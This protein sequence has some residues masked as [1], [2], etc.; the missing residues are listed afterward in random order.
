MILNY[1]DYKNLNDIENML[2]TGENAERKI[3]DKLKSYRYKEIGKKLLNKIINHFLK[4]DK[5]T[6]P[7]KYTYEKN[8]YFGEPYDTF[9]DFF[10][11][12]LTDEKY[13]EI[14]KSSENCKMIV[15]NESWIEAIG[16]IKDTKKIVRLKKESP[17]FLKEM[18][19]LEIEVSEYHYIDTKLL[20]S[21]YHRVHMPVK[22][23]IKRMIPIEQKDEF[24][25]KNSLWIL[26]I[27]TEKSPVYVLLVGESAIQDFN[28][29]VEKNDSLDIFDTIGYYTW[30]S[31]TIILYNPSDF[32]E[33]Q[34]KENT[35]VFAGDC[36][37]K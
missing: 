21:Y 4:N 36:V 11:R 27:E 10:T 12:K 7:T 17:D 34:V 23:T 16:D 31:Q 2:N 1:D 5:K 28:F 6:S 35:T 33:I 24:F 32:D 3:L 22:G 37:F 13:K 9:M 15:P 18:K 14:K 25:G 29:L 30:G 8:W 26:E 20:I 19:K